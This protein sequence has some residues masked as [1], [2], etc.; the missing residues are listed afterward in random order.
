MYVCVCVRVF[1]CAERD[2]SHA[3]WVYTWMDHES[4]VVIYSSFHPSAA[5]KGRGGLYPQ[6]TALYSSMA[7]M[8]CG[9]QT[10]REPLG[11]RRCGG[12]K[13]HLRNKQASHIML[14]LLLVDTDSSVVWT[15]WL[16]VT[17]HPV[18][19]GVCSFVFSGSHIHLFL[20]ISVFLIIGKTYFDLA[21]MSWSYLLYPV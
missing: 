14:Q 13:W 18:A 20:Y 7:P 17:L 12:W 9:S 4:A 16:L 6:C 15:L 2:T 19:G 1:E 3:A 21:L 10:K 5:C 8:W 11:F